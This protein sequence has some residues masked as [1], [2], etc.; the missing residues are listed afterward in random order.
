MLEPVWNY[1]DRRLAAVQENDDLSIIL[2]VDETGLFRVA[3]DQT[4]IDLGM[5]AARVL[6]VSDTNGP[7]TFTIAGPSVQI[8]PTSVDRLIQIKA[9]PRHIFTLLNGTL[10]PGISITP[11][12]IIAGRVLNFVASAETLFTFTLRA[13]NGYTVRDRTFEI[14]ATPVQS[15]ATFD[16]ELIAPDTFDQVLNLHYRL[17][18][19]AERASSIALTIPVIDA[20]GELPLI[21]V[22]YVTGLVRTPRDHSGLPPGISLVDGQLVG[23][24]DPKARPGRYFFRITI[25]DPVTPSSLI[26]AI[27]VAETVEELSNIIPVVEWLT[28]K[29][30]LGSLFEHDISY[31]S[32]VATAPNTTPVYSLS[33]RSGALP[34]GLF[35]TPDGLIS[36]TVG[37]VDSTT[38]FSFTVRARLGVQFVDRTFSITVREKYDSDDVV[39]LYLKLAVTDRNAVLPGYT[40]AIDPTA[41]YRASDENFGLAS[42][43][44]V[45]LIGGLDGT[46]AGGG[47]TLD[48]I[49]IDLASIL[50]IDG[51]PAKSEDNPL[52]LALAGSYAGMMNEIYDY[53]DGTVELILGPHRTAVARNA[54]GEIIY[55]VIYRE[56]YDRQEGAG[57]FSSTASTPVE[58]RVVWA[59]SNQ[60]DPRY[61]YPPSLRNVRLDLVRDVGFAVQDETRRYKIGPTGPEAL[62]LWMR[63]QQTD[64]ITSVSGF[65]AALPIAY[66]K[67]GKSA[68]ALKALMKNADLPPSG[69]LL[70]FKHYYLTPKLRLR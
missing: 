2:D 3:A 40:S 4:S 16:L 13:T 33:P 24:V 15:A 9:T 30:A 27:S 26:F 55:E 12:G 67:P 10:P 70:K 62:P 8:E 22:S 39:D 5:A 34:P 21:S 1:S 66:L 50:T 54:L 52:L 28:P 48:S 31:F 11:E 6:A 68:P 37:M 25:N 29:G 17:L 51:A 18:T 56:L 60:G 42:Q 32:V 58:Q 59:Q 38:T 14:A 65:V 57:G 53:H 20:D 45:Y 49:E 69:K 46:G 43:A 61:V 44:M 63:S 36:G 35:L 7:L 41:I 19:S 47:P 23:I 64:A